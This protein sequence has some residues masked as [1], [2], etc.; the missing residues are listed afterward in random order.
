MN[1]AFGAQGE[2]I[3]TEGDCDAWCSSVEL[4]HFA[5]SGRAAAVLGQLRRSRTALVIYGFGRR[6]RAAR[7]VR[8]FT[9]K[10]RPI[11]RPPN[12]N[13]HPLTAATKRAASS[14]DSARAAQT[15]APHPP[16]VMRIS[17]IIPHSTNDGGGSDLA[18][19]NIS[20]WEGLFTMAIVARLLPDLRRWAEVSL[21]AGPESPADRR[22]SRA[23]RCGW[24]DCGVGEN[25]GASDVTGIRSVCVFC[26]S[27]TP[28]DGRYQRAA[29]ELAEAVVGRG[30]Q[31]VY[32]GGRVGLMGSLA[33]AALAKGGRVIGVLPVGLFRREV[34]H[35]GLTELRQVR[36]MHERK[37]LMYDLADGFIA[38]PGGLGTLEELAEVATWAQLG[39]HAKAIVLLDVDDYW[40]PL[41]QQLDRM[42]EVGLMKEANRV[43]IRLARSPEAALDAL[44]TVPAFVEKWITEGER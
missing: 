43:I 37:Q 16:Q 5:G 20:H 24:N 17:T 32:G 8:R 44:A 15:T 18:G 39:L 31:L 14:A 3:V 7:S 19:R 9:Q 34:G 40:A 30:L 35:T 23:Q 4:P 25:I 11:S 12:P 26:G 27:S 36:S 2:G 38:L 13:T 33:D 10:P 21:I 1:P 42:V 28:A 22:H 6:V 29:I 41:V